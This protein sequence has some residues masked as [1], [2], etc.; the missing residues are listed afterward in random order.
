MWQSLRLANYELK[1]QF[2]KDSILSI[3]MLNP[4]TMLF[5]IQRSFTLILDLFKNISTT[6]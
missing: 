1:W 4:L 5:Q 6:L 2:S 3:F